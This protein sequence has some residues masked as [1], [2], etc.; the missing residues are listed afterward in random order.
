MGGSGTRVANQRVVIAGFNRKAQREG[1]T[2]LRCN[3]TCRNMTREAE[4]MMNQ[5]FATLDVF[6]GQSLEISF[7]T[8]S[9]S[10]SS[11]RRCVV[12]FR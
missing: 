6:D 2:Q 1:A 4:V 11:D 9:C 8:P 7:L 12:C 3:A 10:S 5:S